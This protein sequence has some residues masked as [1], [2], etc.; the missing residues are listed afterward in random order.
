MLISLLSCTDDAVFPCCSCERLCQRKQVSLF[1]F[2]L[3]KYNTDAWV[4]LRA[5]IVENNSTEKLYICQHCRPFL[6]KNA[7][8]SRCVL[9]GLIT[10]SV[11]VELKLPDVLRKQLIQRQKHFR[12]LCGWVHILVKCQHIMLYRLARAA[13]FSFHCPLTTHLIPC[14]RFGVVALPDLQWFIIVNDVPTK[15]KPLRNPS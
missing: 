13:C 15:N 5:H 10:E 8:P 9:N 11:P 3:D 1:N 14:P 7:I 2:S 4:R 6:D 12:L